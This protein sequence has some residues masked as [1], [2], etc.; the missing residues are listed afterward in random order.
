MNNSILIKTKSNTFIN[1][2][3]W[4]ASLGNLQLTKSSVNK[5]LSY[6]KIAFKIKYKY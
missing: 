2:I 5:C 3:T 6:K 4:Y 1:Q